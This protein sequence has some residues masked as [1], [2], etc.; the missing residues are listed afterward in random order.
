MLRPTKV[1]QAEGHLDPVGPDVQGI[2]STPL[3]EQSLFGTNEAAQQAFLVLSASI[4]QLAA[5]SND[6]LE[7]D[8]NFH[9]AI[10]WLVAG[11]IQSL[12]ALERLALDL[13]A[14]DAFVVSRTG[15]ETFVN[16]GYICAEGTGAAERIQRHALQKQFREMLR[17]NAFLNSN[18]GTPKI[19][20]TPQPGTELHDALQEFTGR[21][22]REITAWTP[23]TVEQRIQV[24]EAKFGKSVGAQFS[25]PL[26]GIYRQA[27]EIAHGTLYGALF[28]FGVTSGLPKGKPVDVQRHSKD[29]LKMLMVLMGTATCGAISCVDRIRGSTHAESLKKQIGEFHRIV[30]PTST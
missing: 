23:A 15:F 10:L 26:Y 24:I 14:R 13:L 22:G 1:S 19:P 4:K 2:M 7:C 30:L 16:I 18:F 21:K 5:L 9:T 6:L 29:Q 8:D 3:N 20:L 25:Y 11:G 17:A 12:A 27:S 28:A